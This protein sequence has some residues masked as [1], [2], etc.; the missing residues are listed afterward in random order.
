VSFATRY[1]RNAIGPL[2]T[3]G[4]VKDGFAVCTAKQCLGCC[5]A[6][7]RQILK[8]LLIVSGHSYASG[9]PYHPTP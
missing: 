2:F 9:M 4:S 5:I 1:F 3:V 7:A 6:S 8:P